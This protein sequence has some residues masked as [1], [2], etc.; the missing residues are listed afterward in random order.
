[1]TEH[2]DTPELESEQAGEIRN[3][4]YRRFAQLV[5]SPVSRRVASPRMVV[6]GAILI[7]VMVLVVLWGS[8][9]GFRWVAS[10]SDY[11]LRFSEI[12]LIPAPEPWVLCGRSGILEKV[13]TEANH[14]ETISL[15]EIDLKE[16][17]NDFRRNPWVKDVIRLE[18]SYRR[19]AVHVTYRRPVAVVVLG[20]LNPVAHPIDG[21]AV[22]LPVSNVDWV[23][24]KSPFQVKGFSQPLIEV[25]G[26]ES[27][28][29]PRFGLQDR[30]PMVQRAAK[31][32]ELLQR[33]PRSTPQGQVVPNIVTIIIPDEPGHP[34]FLKDSEQN[35]L[36]WGQAPGDESSG[37]PSS[38][39]RWKMMLDWVDGHGPLNVK[40][41]NYLDLSRTKAVL[42]N[43]QAPKR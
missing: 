34:F 31:L 8:K 40:Y 27:P 5:E 11:Q 9:L 3:P 25:R 6:A 23:S 41:P 22:Y 39:A 18:T 2:R 14:G 17:E 28:T 21:E 30:D 33:Q 36:K 35:L 16:L 24:N 19:L 1:V 7:G 37:E 13:R 20:R 15:L 4:T 42:V 43:R 38:E 32:A 10:Q 29:P 12:E 26:V